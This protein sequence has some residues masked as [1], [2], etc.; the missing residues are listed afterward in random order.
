MVWKKVEYVQI[1]I[2]YVEFNDFDVMAS[3]KQRNTTINFDHYRL[4]LVVYK[5]VIWYQY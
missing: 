4:T 5:F 1:W 3:R 2:R